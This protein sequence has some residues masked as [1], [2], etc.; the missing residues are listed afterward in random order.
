M[1][2]LPLPAFAL[3]LF[4]LTFR[5]APIEPMAVGG[6]VAGLLVLVGMVLPWRWPIV[7]AACL[8]SADHAIALWVTAAPVNILGASGF[9]LALL[10]LLQSADLGRC[11]REATVGGGVMRSQIVRWAGFATLTLATVMLGLVAAGSLSA[12]IPAAA[13]PM[14]AALGALGVITAVAVAA[15]HAARGRAA[16]PAAREG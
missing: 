7:G 8:F 5:V 12:T 13:A 10:G 4:A 3:A 14:L 9:G 2:R 11:T 6:L 15:V 1:R 16:P